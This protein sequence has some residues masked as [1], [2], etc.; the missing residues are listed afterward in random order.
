VIFSS[1]FLRLWAPLCCETPIAFP[2]PFPLEDECFLTLP[3]RMGLWSCRP[4]PPP[5]FFFSLGPG[6]LL[7]FFRCENASFNSFVFPFFPLGVV[8][9]L[10]PVSFF[11]FAHSNLSFFYS[12]PVAA[13]HIGVPLF[14]LFWHR[15]FLHTLFLLFETFFCLVDSGLFFLVQFAAVSC[16]PDTI[17]AR[18]IIFLSGSF[19]CYLVL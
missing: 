4:S 18:L 1:L 15:C 11:F 10:G 5:Q 12:Q 16:S 9:F 7:F 13:N 17:G 2:N 19:F 6:V 3:F 14:P 8:F